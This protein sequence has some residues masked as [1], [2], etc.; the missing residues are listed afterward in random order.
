MRL[1]GIQAEDFLQ[2]EQDSAAFRAWLDRSASPA[3]LMAVLGPAL[4]RRPDGGPS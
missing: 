1:I 3:E 2:L 4:R